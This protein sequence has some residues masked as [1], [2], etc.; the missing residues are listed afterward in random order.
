MIVSDQTFLSLFPA[1]RSTAPD[2]ILLRLR[3]GADVAATVQ[4]CRA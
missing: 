1:R 4:R 2:H 3:P